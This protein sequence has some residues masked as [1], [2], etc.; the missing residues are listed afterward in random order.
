[1]CGLVGLLA[2]TPALSGQLGALMQPMLEG[3]TQRGPDSA[4]FA[5]FNQSENRA[6]WRVNVLA[7]GDDYDWAPVASTL[8]TKRIG[9]KTSIFPDKRHAIIDVTGDP[10]PVL[11][12]LAA[13]FPEL[14]VL[15]TGHQ[16]DIYKDV[17]LPAEV[18]SRYRLAE[19]TG[20]HAIG[21]TRMATESEITPLHAHPFVA[22]PDFCIVH[23][24]SLSNP[25]SVRKR[26]ERHGIRFDSNNDTES[27]ARFIQ[28][29]LAEGDDLE[30]AVNFGL[31]E[32][33][34]F[35]TLLMGDGKSMALV[36][37]PFACKPAVVA[38]TDEYVAIASEF[39][40][41][42]HLPHINQ[43]DI[44]EPKPELVYVWKI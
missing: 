19:R 7:P 44:F 4:G 30:A 11:V 23:N 18:A 10:A 3:M 35:Y 24:G 34:G 31:Q 43:A 20:T 21:H 15:A 9:G 12:C 16:M 5:I 39:R 6:A 38:E 25:N 42:K 33:D 37:D 40:S 14:N 32:L 22:G 2:K 36:R 17:G 41:L 29:R 8:T 27:A 1:M 28:W 13:E 26:I